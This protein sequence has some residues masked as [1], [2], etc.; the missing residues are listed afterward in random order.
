MQNRIKSK[1]DKGSKYKQSWTVLTKHLVL[2]VSE[3]CLTN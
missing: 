3:S 1:K 2:P